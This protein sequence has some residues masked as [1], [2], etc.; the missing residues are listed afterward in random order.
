[1]FTGDGRLPV[2]CFRRY[3]NIP[4]ADWVDDRYDYFFPISFDHFRLVHIMGG[5]V[6][7]RCC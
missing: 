3:T 1:M 4:D 6:K 7:D 2:H 5:I